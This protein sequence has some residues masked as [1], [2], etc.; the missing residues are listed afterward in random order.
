MPR[1]WSNKDER[2]YDHIK[3]SNLERGVGE[4]RAEEIA[5][6]TVNKTRREE[7]RTPNTTTQGTGNPNRGY[8][9][10]SR[11]E[12]YNIARD[13]DIPGRSR[14]NKDELIDAIRGGK[15]SR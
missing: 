2:M 4:E 15:R 8:E 9:A 1:G 3:D 10:R 7:G 12:L 13:K 5:A 6:R 14:M 11:D